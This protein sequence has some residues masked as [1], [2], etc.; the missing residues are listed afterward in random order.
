MGSV[1]GECLCFTLIFDISTANNIKYYEN[2]NI[3]LLIMRF[4]IIYVDIS[5]FELFW[6][7]R[8]TSRNSCRT[9][10]Y[11]L[12]YLR[13]SRSD[14]SVRCSTCC[15][16]TCFLVPHKSRKSTRWDTP[17]IVFLNFPK[18]SRKIFEVTHW[19]VCTTYILNIL[20]PF[21]WEKNGNICCLWGPFF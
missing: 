3:C 17:D 20:S 15:G 7:T 6:Y 4:A 11:A 5:Q 1:C 8:T 18:N 9:S 12:N 14:P 2:G 13:A 21:R 16:G 10:T 19:D